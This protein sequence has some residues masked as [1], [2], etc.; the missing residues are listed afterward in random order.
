MTVT[1][2]GSAKRPFVHFHG[3]SPD[4]TFCMD[5]SNES[6]SNYNLDFM[7]MSTQQKRKGQPAGPLPPD[8]RPS[9]V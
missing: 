3:F 7:F 9:Q 6:V 5:L 8:H 4:L 1:M 2:V